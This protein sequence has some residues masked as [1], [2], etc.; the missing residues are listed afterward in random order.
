VALV[1]EDATAFQYA[2]TMGLLP[3]ISKWASQER[4]RSGYHFHYR[5]VC[6]VADDSPLR[7]FDDLNRAA[8][9]DRVEWL[10]VHPLSVSG[11][12]VPEFVLRQEGLAPAPQRVRYTHSHTESLRLASDDDRRRLEVAFVWDDALRN[13]PS[14]AA[15]LRKLDFPALDRLEVPQIAVAVRGDLPQSTRL[16]SLLVDYRDPEGKR[17]FDRVDDW[18]ERYRPVLAWNEAVGVTSLS[19]LA[20]N[21]SLDEIGR[22]LLQSCR[23]RG[24]PP[25]V[26][27]VMSGGGA[28]CSYQVGALAAIEEQLEGLRRQN[29]DCPLDINL[30]VGTSGGAINSTPVAM[31]I[32]ATSAGRRDLQAVWLDL[33]QRDLVRPTWIV[34]ANIG[35]WFALF[36]AA[37]WLWAARRLGPEPRQPQLWA[38]GLIVLSALAFLAAYVRWKPWTFLGENHVWHHLWLWV[39]FGFAPAAWCLLTLGAATLVVQAVATGRG[40]TLKLPHRILG[41]TLTA[42]LFGLPLAQVLTV[43]FFQETLSTGA[44]MQEALAENMPRL[45]DRHLERQLQPPLELAAAS[46]ENERLQSTS[47]QMFERGLFQRDL[48]ITGNCL[49]QTTPNLPSDLYFFVQAAPRSPPVPFGSRGVALRERP[50]MLLDVVLGSGTIFPVFPSRTLEDFPEDGERVELV[51]GGFA[52]N[53]PIEAAVLWGATHV[54]LIE[55]TPQRRLPRRNFAEN[56]AAALV[57]LHRQTQLVDARSKKQVVVFT[58]APEAPHL[59]VLDFADNLLAASVQTGYRDA[60]RGARFRKELGEPV[61]TDIKHQLHSP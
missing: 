38:I 24:G 39:T 2:A 56:S 21:V 1:R 53:S 12:I 10:F 7:T 35:V 52:H 58:L 48:V 46:D 16:Q 14:L 60:M 57:H 51:D 43:L 61:F 28:K 47:R 5:T 30:V 49:D 19:D 13:S 17:M 34:R 20:Q 27:V 59:C 45:I 41:G 25:R 33:D 6:V 15:R 3:A 9:T 11:R 23:A 50:E 8:H 22:M 31:S 40:R 37:F 32:S 4:T 36:F 18:R 26:A 29:P 42:C 44:G 54:F 55:A